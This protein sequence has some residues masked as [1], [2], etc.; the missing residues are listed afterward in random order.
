[1]KPS[2]LNICTIAALPAPAFGAG[3]AAAAAGPERINKCAS[4]VLIK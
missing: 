1:M 3:S 4:M 2:K